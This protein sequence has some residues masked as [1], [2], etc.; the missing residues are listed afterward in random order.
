[1]KLA[2]P[3]GRGEAD[4]PCRRPALPVSV[5]FEVPWGVKV[6][7]KALILPSISSLHLFLPGIPVCL[8]LSKSGT[9]CSRWL[10]IPHVALNTLGKCLLGAGSSLGGVPGSGTK[11]GP[12]SV[13]WGPPG[14]ET[15]ALLI[16]HEGH[17]A[18][19]GASLSWGVGDGSRSVKISK[20]FS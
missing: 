14:R 6:L 4:G 17:A 12:E 19:W 1:M 18:P 5:D 7:F 15:Q 8:L 16:Q 10:Q 11:A 9:P 3:A 13:L 2:V 20:H